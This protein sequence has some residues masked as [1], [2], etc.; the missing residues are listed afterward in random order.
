MLSL[1]RSTTASLDVELRHEQNYNTTDLLSYVQS[2]IPKLT[3]EQKGIYD[4]ITQIVSKGV[5]KIF[6]LDARGGTGKMF[7]IK[8][9]LATIRSQKDI[10]LAL[11]SS[12]I[13]ATLLPGGRTAHSALKLPLS[14][15][16]IET[17][18]CNIFKTSS[19]GKQTLPVI[20]RSTPADEINACL[21]Y[22]T[23]SRKDVKID[24]KTIDQLDYSHINCWKLGTE[25][26]TVVETDETAN[27]PIE[28]LNSLDLLRIPRTHCNRKS[29]ENLPVIMLRNINQLKLCNGT[30]LAVRKL[31]SNFVEATI[32]T[33]PFKGEH[34]LFLAFL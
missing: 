24:Y 22:F 3:F 29:A 33:G 28:Y 20:P 10:A 25:S 23:V 19:M 8:L 13:A 5:G 12:G 7:L 21:K 26:D 1:N 2:N 27:Y 4:Q 9:I 15:Q 34:S 30:R 18:T 32:L 16:F 11:K 6:F 17:P 14:M 31:M